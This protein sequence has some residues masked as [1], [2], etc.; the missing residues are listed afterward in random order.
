MVLNQFKLYASAVV[1]KIAFIGFLLLIA[2]KM[3]N[4]HKVA[5]AFGAGT[6]VYWIFAMKAIFIHNYYTVIMMIFICILASTCIFYIIKI[7]PSV[8]VKILFAIIFL[9]II[10]PPVYTQSAARLSKSVSI[11]KIS[12]YI[13]DNTKLDELVLYEGYYSPI[14]IKTK[15]GMV[16]TFRLED[17]KI[18]QSIKTLGFAETMKKYN[19]KFLITPYETP[20]YDD[21]APLFADD[22]SMK[23]TTFDRKY[24]IYK[25]VGIGKGMT[26][27]RENSLKRIIDEYDIKEKFVYVGKIDDFNVYSFTD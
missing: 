26:S 18:V 16:R 25:R 10:I 11:N 4:L 1:F 9:A 3:G 17:K 20:N 22:S 5:F 2:S 13:I 21:F 8:Y 12:Q 6:L 7:S 15:R 27:E 24:L 23:S 14:A 19:I